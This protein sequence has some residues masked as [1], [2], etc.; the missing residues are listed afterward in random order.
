MR[1]SIRAIGP[2]STAFSVTGT[3]AD[4]TIDFYRGSQLILPNDNWKS[5]GQ[6]NIENIGVAPTS[7]KESA[8]LVTLDRAVIRPSFGVRTT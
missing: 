8:I 2:S 7:D 3:L 1:R 4:P 6:T 5:D